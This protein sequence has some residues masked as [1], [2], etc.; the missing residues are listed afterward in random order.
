MV[1]CFH[2]QLNSS[3]NQVMHQPFTSGVRGG[4]FSISQQDRI[5]FLTRKEILIISFIRI[6]L[7]METIDHFT[8]KKALDCGLIARE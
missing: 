1:N 4:V 5:F 6:Q 8:K 2:V 3:D 7:H